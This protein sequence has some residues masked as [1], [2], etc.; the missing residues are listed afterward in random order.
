MAK[1]ISA[2]KP[3]YLGLLNA[4]SVGEGRAGVVLS[5]WAS[6]T[7]DK[8]LGKALAL[9]AERETDHHDLFRSRIEE[10]GFGLRAPADDAGFAR[11]VAFY[12]S[13]ASDKKKV[14]RSRKGQDGDGLS[15]L[16]ERV[17]TDTALDTVTRH[18]LQWYVDEERDSAKRL[19][20]AYSR[21]LKG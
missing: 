11:T 16:E 5:A 6:A 20:R 15:A 13:D 19:D 10:L 18:L 12:G 3:P 17:R 2:A 7:T 9:V 14:K 4:I 21:V 8:R 1:Q